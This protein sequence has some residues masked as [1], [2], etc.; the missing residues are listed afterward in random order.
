MLFV[1]FK[2]CLSAGMQ[3]VGLKS[4]KTGE[5]D[6]GR[7][8][9]SGENVSAW[10]QRA[11]RLC[12]YCV[13]R[14]GRRYLDRR[15]AAFPLTVL[16]TEHLRAALGRPCL[17]IANHVLIRAENAPLGRLT[18]ARAL[19]LL[20]Q[21][22]DSFI[23][24]R[25][26]WEETGL[27]LHVVAKSDRGWWSPRPLLR[28]LQKRVGQPFGK[29]LLEGM[30]FVPIEHN[31]A[32]FHRTFFQSAAETV[33]AGRP[34]LIFPGKLQ[35]DES[36]CRDALIEENIMDARILPGAAHLARKFLLPVLP[37]FIQG[38]DSWRPDQPACVI[39]GPAFSPEGMTKSDINRTMI[40]HMR[41]LR[42]AQKN[43]NENAGVYSPVSAEGLPASE[44]A[45]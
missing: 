3:N 15:C 36:G 9:P 45:P 23:L 5:A 44:S 40:E 13:T 37:A 42:L 16:G 7:R 2:L 17:I 22:P 11:G 33:K 27:P 1:P 12:G 28:F 38:G 41:D 26:V 6:M 8:S 31:P 21:P 30:E 29:G 34:I 43:I 32:C 14:H 20:N 4:Q 25:I 35:C 18:Q 10:M 39:F 19:T 24:R